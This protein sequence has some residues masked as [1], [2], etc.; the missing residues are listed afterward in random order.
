[1]VRWQEKPAD[2]ELYNNSVAGLFWGSKKTQ[3]RQIIMGTGERADA[4]GCTRRQ[5]TSFDN[6]LYTPIYI[7][8]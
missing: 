2:V 4:E 1:M 5:T 6:T 8:I 3:G 7:Y